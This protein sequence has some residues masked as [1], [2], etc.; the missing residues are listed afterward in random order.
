MFHVYRHTSPSGKSYVGWTGRSVHVRFRHHVSDASR[1]S[2]T[3]F[4][5]A[6]RKYGADAFLTE[7]LGVYESAFAAKEAEASAIASLGCRAP[8]GYNATDG[9]DGL[10]NPSLET[11]AKLSAANVGKVRSSEARAKGAAALRGKTGRKHSAETKAKIAAANR[12]RAVSDSAR[13]KMSTSSQNRPPVSAVTRAKI[14]AACKAAWTPERR[15]A[16]ALRM[17]ERNRRG[18]LHQR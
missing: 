8:V 18:V 4:H 3:P 7:T 5:R 1:G 6:L 16:A 15:A 17:S 10:V 11:R 13:D 12:G 14:G 2:S 9:R